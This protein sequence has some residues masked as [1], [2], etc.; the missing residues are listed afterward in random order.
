MKAEVPKGNDP[1]R[2][3]TLIC[4]RSGERILM[5]LG[6]IRRALHTACPHCGGKLVVRK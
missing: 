5:P 4:E 2:K 1:N 6:E 3:M